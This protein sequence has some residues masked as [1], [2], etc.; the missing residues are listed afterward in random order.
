MTQKINWSDIT[1]KIGIVLS[2]LTFLGTGFK[3]LNYI[4]NINTNVE[5]I[6][7][8]HQIDNENIKEKINILNNQFSL[9][10][11]QLKEMDNKKEDKKINLQNQQAILSDKIKI[12]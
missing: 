6:I 1:I 8:A 9:V 7:Q 5:L 12:K 10:F 2:I 4:S 11:Q 3:I